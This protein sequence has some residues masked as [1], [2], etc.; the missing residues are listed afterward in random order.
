MATCLEFVL[1]TL[2]IGLS[3]QVV[4]RGAPN[5]FS[6]ASCRQSDACAGCACG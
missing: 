1:T 5:V 2:V 6:F 4:A 3:G